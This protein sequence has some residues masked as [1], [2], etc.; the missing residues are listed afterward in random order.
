M[1][2]GQVGADG[3]TTE[4]SAMVERYVDAHDTAKAA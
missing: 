1:A 4:I 2:H 3:P